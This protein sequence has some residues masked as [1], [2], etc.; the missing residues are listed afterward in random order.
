[1]IDL[2]TYFTST[3]SFFEKVNSEENKKHAVFCVLHPNYEEAIWDR[4]KPLDLT[5]WGTKHWDV[6]LPFLNTNFYLYQLYNNCDHLIKWHNI[7]K[8]NQEDGTQIQCRLNA[9]RHL[10]ENLVGLTSHAQDGSTVCTAPFEI[11]GIRKVL[12]LKRNFVTGFY[13]MRC[14]DQPTA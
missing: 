8:A 9:W 5:K 10:F 6:D 12:Q 11:L 7:S 4:K 13:E 2:L 3:N 14:I 1:M